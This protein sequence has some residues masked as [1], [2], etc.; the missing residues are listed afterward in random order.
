MHARALTVLS[1]A[2]TALFATN[3]LAAPPEGDAG[4]S[5][6]GSATASGTGTRTGMRGIRGASGKRFRLHADTE[7]LGVSIFDPDGPGDA[8]GA[9]GFGVGRPNTV[10][11]GRIGLGQIQ[12]TPSYGL[13]FAYL[14]AQERALVGARASFIVNGTFDEAPDQEL[15]QSTTTV[16]GYLVPYFQWMFL[17]D[18]WARPY[19][20]VR[21]GFGGGATKVR[22]QGGGM[23]NEVTVHTISPNVGVGGGAHLFII[24]AFSFDI[25]LNVDYFAPHSRLSGDVPDDAEDWEEVGDLVSIGVLA[26]FSVWFP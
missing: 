6:S 22:A 12:Q 5:T 21:L 9:A 1:F 23:E 17:P 2:A 4:V 26:G 7:F 19:V 14:F 24:D 8:V 25:G 18:N 20:E 10:D 3:A 16:G 13:G 15:D 11:G